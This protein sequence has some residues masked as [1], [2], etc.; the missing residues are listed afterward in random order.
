MYREDTALQVLKSM[1]RENRHYALRVLAEAQYYKRFGGMLP[2]CVILK[3]IVKRYH[4][5]SA[6][7]F[8]CGTVPLISL[9]Q[10]A[11]GKKSRP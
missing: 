10:L 7:S 9:A 2:L 11:K 8:I 5:I 6:Y 4:R 3:L 1:Y